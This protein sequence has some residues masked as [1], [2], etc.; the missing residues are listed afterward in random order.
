MCY[1]VDGRD[2]LIQGKALVVVSPPATSRTWPGTCGPPI[3][4]GWN[5]DSGILV[6]DY[7]GRVLGTYIGGQS[8]QSDYKV[9]PPINTPSIDGIHF[10]SPI[11]PTLEGIRAA[12]RHDPTFGGLDVN[13]D[14]V[15]GPAD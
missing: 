7:K 3:A 2:V 15:W 12:V 6:F 1:E 8:D 14:F 11:Y 5:G 4:F 9:D 13:V 10:V